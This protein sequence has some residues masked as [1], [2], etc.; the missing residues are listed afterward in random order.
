MHPHK[1]DHDKHKEARVHKMIGKGAVTGIVESKVK[2]AITEHD[3]QLH[4]GA[5]THLKFANGG[6][7][8][9]A[10]SKPRKD[11]SSRHKNGKT[12]VNVI[13]APHPG[14]PPMPAMPGG[15][16]APPM[17]PGGPMAS[18]PAPMRPPMPVG[19][20][21]PGPSI[22]PPPGAMPMRK[23]GGGV[24][25]GGAATGVGREEKTQKYGKSARK[26]A[27]ENR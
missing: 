7:I 5:K 20:P 10:M 9:G 14:T 25:E 6:A 17:P 24:Y 27:A 8:P 26:I 13:V 11:R 4:G 21:G 16:M 12:Q 23:R 18:G 15:G 22:M 2:R 1:H 19:M 3:K